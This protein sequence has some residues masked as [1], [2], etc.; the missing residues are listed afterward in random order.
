H[1]LALR[2]D[3]SV[4]TWGSNV[5]GQLGDG[6]TDDSMRPIQVPLPGPASALTAGLL[7]SLALSDRNLLTWGW[8]ALGQLGD[9]SM[10][11]RHAPTPVLAGVNSVGGGA[12]HSLA[13]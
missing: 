6:T 1:S 3:G 8:N 10:T 13:S 11:D 4:F 5:V 2:D 7:H 12:L 9:G